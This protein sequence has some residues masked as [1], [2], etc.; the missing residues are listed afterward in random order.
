VR[1][2]PRRRRFWVLTIGGVFGVLLAALAV[3]FVVRYLPAI[4]ALQDGQRAANQADA[5][6]RSG[7]DHLTAARLDQLDGLLAQAQ[8]DFGAKSGI[9]D[10][11][12]IL[13][14]VGRLPVLGDQ[15]SGLRGLRA[16]GTAGA[17][18][19]RDFIPLLRQVLP[20]TAPASGSLVARLTTFAEGNASAIAKLSQDFDAVDQAVAQ[21]PRTARLFGPLSTGRDLAESLV[22]RL[23]GVRP[24]IGLLGIL[25]EIAG[26]GTHRYLLLLNNPG[27]ERPA[28]G[29]IGA[30]GEVDLSEGRVTGE[31]FTQSDFANTVTSMP[32]PPGL[33]DQLFHGKPLQLGDTGWSPDFPTAAAQSAKFYELATGHTLD[34]VIGLDPV[35]LGYVLQVTGQV[36]VPGYPQVVSAQDTLLTLNEVINKARPG[37]PGKAYLAPFGQALVNRMIGS[38]STQVAGIASALLRG[39]QEKHVVMSLTNAG[40]MARADAAGFTA[41]MPNPIGDALAVVD[42]NVSGNKEDLFVSRK[43]ALSASVGSGGQVE[44]TLTLQ[45]TNPVQTDPALQV[46]ANAQFGG[47]YRDYLRVYVPEQ[48]TLESMS[49]QDGSAVSTVSPASVDYELQREAIAYLLVVPPGHTVT[50]TVKYGGPLVDATVSPQHYTLAWS[51]EIGAPAWPISLTLTAGGRRQ[52]VAGDLGVDRS[53][54]LIAG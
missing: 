8:V 33:D 53:F 42:A 29:F 19:G 18:M 11:S 49:A 23:D 26:S 14:V 12:W 30:V 9:V 10:S 13:D 2:A 43:F 1:T 5:I 47:Q 39:A 27:E 32:A 46:L 36:S 16:T 28:G 45:Y 3:D 34:G 51:K 41:R 31:S 6:L 22:P 25:P 4:R 40:L 50:L 54:D 17:Q 35:A 24:A 44:D 15:V 38:P 7:V 20:S 48:A 52:Q 37:D 21:I